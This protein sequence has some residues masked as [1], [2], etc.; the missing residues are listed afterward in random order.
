M[1]SVTQ[2]VV[3]SCSGG[4]QGEIGLVR[5]LGRQGVEVVFVT[6]NPA[7]HALGSRY[8]KRVILIESFKTH[9]M[10]V[11]STLERY[12]SSQEEKPVL[13][14]TADPDLEL[15][16]KHRT[17]LEKLFHFTSPNNEI[18]ETC[19]DKGRFFRFGVEEKFPLPNTIVPSSTKD[20]SQC[21]EGWNYP[22]IL[23]PANPIAW[24]RPE[25]QDLVSSK[26]AVLA[27]SPDDLAK[28]YQSIAKYNPDMVIQEYIP[29]RDDRLHSVHIYMDRHGHVQAYFVGRKVRTY[30]AYAGIGCFVVSEYS[31]ILVDMSVDILNKLNYK[32]IALLQFKRDEKTNKFVLLEINARASS[33]NHLA[34]HCGVNIPYFAYLDVQQK[35][36]PEIPLQENGVKYVYLKPD[37]LA[38]KEYHSHGDWTFAQWLG[39]FRG[40]KTYQL[41]CLDDPMPFLKQFLDDAISTVTRPVKWALSRLHFSAS[42]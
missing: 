15:I 13:F 33:W 38:F 42:S 5:S 11:I 26:K 8:V 27:A 36:L 1:T 10:E 23:K 19:L 37:V 17:Q 28:L 41:M 31:Q 16:S 12:A 2:A 29:G 32:G 39:S 6:E 14:P 25:I 9:P 4:S 30:P 40:K 18:V 7:A 21:S 22:V 24:T 20:L 34:S 35:A 3:L